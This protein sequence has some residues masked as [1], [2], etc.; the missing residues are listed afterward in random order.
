MGGNADIRTCVRVARMYY[1]LGMSQ[2]DIARET[3]L[4]RPT[5]SRLLDRARKEGIVTITVNYPL[6]SVP[7]LEERMAR[8]FGLKKVGVA[9]ITV[10]NM[11]SIRQDVCRMAVEYLLS[12]VTP[13][14]RVGVSWGTTMAHV[15]SILPSSSLGRGISVVQLNGGVALSKFGTEASVVVERFANALGGVAYLLPTPAVV[16]RRETALMVMEDATIASVLDL[17]ARVDVA[18]FSIGYACRDSILYQCG[19]FSDEEYDTL[20]KRGAVG[21]VV[22]RYFTEEGV[23][24]F[25]E[26]DARTIGIQLDQLKRVPVTIG[27]AVGAHRARA[28]LG[29][30]RGGYVNTL[31]TDE[32]TAR[33]ILA[34]SHREEEVKSREGLA[35][36]QAR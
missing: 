25:P 22:S 16:E 7:E 23:V 34:L 21:D 31:F 11:Q 5:I 20:L 29:A 24:A 1:E 27:V 12:I 26:L 35:F 33:D 9:P 17:A 15:A 19:Y 14:S 6:E 4:S 3:G 2:A 10:N 28:V 13:G 32:Q 36:V 8:T 18:F 30:L